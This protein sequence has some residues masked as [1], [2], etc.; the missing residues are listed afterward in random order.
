MS[1]KRQSRKRKPREKSDNEEENPSPGLLP[2]SLLPEQRRTNPKRRATTEGVE[3]YSDTTSLV[4]MKKE[5]QK[6]N[7][8][9]SEKESEDEGEDF[10]TIAGL[11]E[12]VENEG[13]DN[14]VKK[15]QVAV[16]EAFDDGETWEKPPDIKLHHHPMPAG[17]KSTP[18]KHHKLPCHD[19]NNEKVLKG[20][21]KGNHHF[22]RILNRRHSLPE[23]TVKNEKLIDNE[24]AELELAKLRKYF[25]AVDSHPLEISTS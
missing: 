5:E 12:E 7:E 13:V 6:E 18:G 3:R 14:N 20:S 25:K 10:F 9:G 15:D 11:F 2:S 4:V 17:G 23:L 1:P 24:T 21:S 8:T 22:H 16:R 19:K